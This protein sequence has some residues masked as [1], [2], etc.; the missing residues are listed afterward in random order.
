MP[1]A[2]VPRTP[3]KF[4]PCGNIAIETADGSDEPC[5]EVRERESGR[6]AAGDSRQW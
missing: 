6:P 4:S 3:R 5:S 1:A 2:A